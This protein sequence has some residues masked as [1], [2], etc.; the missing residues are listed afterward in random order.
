MGVQGKGGGALAG[1]PTG[2]GPGLPEHL[3]GRAAGAGGS[4]ARCGAGQ[5][6]FRVAVVVVPE[7]F[8]VPPKELSLGSLPAFGTGFVSVPRTDQNPCTL[9]ELLIRSPQEVRAL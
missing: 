4:R 8:P 7:Y 1:A 3:P 5:R 6:S 9:R 2:A